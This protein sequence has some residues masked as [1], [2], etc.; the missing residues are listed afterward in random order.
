MD[1]EAV[2]ARRLAA[3][4]G[5]PARLEVPEDSSGE[6]ITVELTR[7]DAGFVSTASLAVQAWAPTRKRARE[8]ILAAAAAV[9]DLEDEPGIFHPEVGGCYRFPDPD[10][11][12]ERYQATVSLSICE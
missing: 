10:A 1:V 7:E 11:R 4:T 6:F 2:V 12:R 8:I 5:V 9:P 3:S